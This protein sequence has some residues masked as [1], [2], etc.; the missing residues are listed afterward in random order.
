M[1]VKFIHAPTMEELVELINGE[2]EDG[3]ELVQVLYV[4]SSFKFGAVL[5]YTTT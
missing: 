2:L 1:E 5:K 4:K 3:A